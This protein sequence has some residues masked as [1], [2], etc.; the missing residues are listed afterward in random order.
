MATRRYHHSYSYLLFLHLQIKPFL[1]QEFVCLAFLTDGEARL[2]NLHVSVQRGDHIL[3]TRNV[4]PLQPE[5]AITR[6]TQTI[7]FNY[8]FS[9]SLL[10]PALFPTYFPFS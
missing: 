1:K 3:S 4:E 5:S 6:P 10:S 2:K 7:I 9:F 8:F